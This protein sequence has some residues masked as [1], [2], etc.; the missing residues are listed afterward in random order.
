MAAEMAG[1]AKG[2]DVI[3][4]L[5]MMVQDQA[6]ASTI[7][8]KAHAMTDITGFGLAGHLR[9]ICDAS[10]V[11]AVLDLDA[12]PLM[13]GALEL[14]GAGVRSTLFGDNR[15]GAGAINGR[16]IDLLFDPQT[17]G[18]L[19]AAVSARAADAAVRKLQDAGY[20]AAVIGEIT[21]GSQITTH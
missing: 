7:L 13:D 19:L 21:E 2:E 12:I 16:S 17:A 8:G 15:I 4:C 5:D 6:A 3:A 20:T 11:G 18:G 9:G 10:G 14:S 1:K